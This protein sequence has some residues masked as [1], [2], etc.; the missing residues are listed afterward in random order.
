MEPILVPGPPKTAFNKQ[1]RVS[2]LIKKQVE[3]FKHLEY[4]LPPEVR[5][6]L[7]QHPIQTEDDAARYIAP[8]TRFLLSKPA[9]TARKKP[10]AM[11]RP[12]VESEGL[13]LAA[14][15]DSNI[16]TKPEST[17]RVAKGPKTAPKRK[18]KN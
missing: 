3:H 9:A 18:R 11:R 17:P 8:F 15:A 10:L 14:A 16:P 2:D 1:R 5:D 12:A 7:P 4:K 6:T 13:A